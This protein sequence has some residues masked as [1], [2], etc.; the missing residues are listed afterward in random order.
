M[1]D[2]QRGSRD[3][4][5]RLVALFGRTDPDAEMQDRAG[6]QPTVDEIFDTDQAEAIA[7]PFDAGLFGRIL[8]YIKPYSRQMA[9]ALIL[10][11]LASA[12]AVAT[13]NLVG[14]AVDVIATGT[15]DP[16]ATWPRLRLLVVLL[17][18]V[19]LF[20][21]ITNRTRLFIM[22]DIGTRIVV[23]I[24]GDMF[25]HL[26]RLSLR[27]YDSYKV[28]RL[29]SRIMGDVSVLRDFVTWSIVGT[30]RSLTTI[31]F[32]VITMFA[33]N[34]RLAAVVVVVLPIMMVVTRLW[35]ARAR[36]AWREVRRRIAIINGYL[37][38]TVSGVRV[39]QSF[40]RESVNER[41]FDGLNRRHLDA[42][43]DAARLSAVFFPTVDIL[44]TLAVALVV[45]YGAFAT[46]SDLSAGDM[47]TFVALADRFF[48]PIRELSRRY[49]QLL[50][51]MAASERIFE[52][53]DLE[54]DVRDAPGAIPLPAIRGE[55]RYEDVWFGY[56]QEPVLKGIDLVIPAGTTTALVGETGAG[57]T[58]MTSLL[59]RFYD[60][61]GGRILV[62]GYDIRDVTMA[63]LRSQMGV[64]LQETF[65]FSGTVAENLRYGRPEAEKDDLEAAARAVGAHEFILRLPRGYDT[66][67][68]E[69]GGN[70][71]VGQRQLV[72]FARALLADPRILILDEATSSVDTETELAIQTA[73]ARL[74]HGRTALVIAHRLSTITRADQI[75]VMHEGRIVERGTHAV[76]LAQRGTY[77]QLYTM[78]WARPDAELRAIEAAD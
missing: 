64:V 77:Q 16:D 38:E 47:V 68:G 19:T 45:V 54:P 58:S 65:L 5:D 32:I 37:N 70:L 40:T 51:A 6:R 8:E 66:E 31:I 73:L 42:N 56:Q 24:R 44:G 22:A 53:L 55:V 10:M 75:V 43:L 7:R 4:S 17:V 76:L 72:S 18:A 1:T 9:A 34:W 78:Q 23:S 60:V 61:T 69:R 50:G 26:Q 20:E 74:L 41:T 63:S 12:A 29:M 2:R 52:L 57:K 71:S 62:D 15:G 14:A 36:Q 21:W 33:R 11:A 67:V 35:S 13:P 28:G 30:A 46:S 48:D 49:N 39:I 59:A 27:F 25:A 3:G